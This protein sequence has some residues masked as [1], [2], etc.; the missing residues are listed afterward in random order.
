MLVSD[1]D[2]SI[3]K[4]ANGPPKKKGKPKVVEPEPVILTLSS[5]DED[6]DTSTSRASVCNR[7]ISVN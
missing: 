3:G 5:D 1:L 7:I 6:E 4:I 2:T